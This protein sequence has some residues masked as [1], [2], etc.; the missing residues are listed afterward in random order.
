[1]KKRNCTN[2]IISLFLY[3]FMCGFGLHKSLNC[4]LDWLLRS[5]LILSVRRYFSLSVG[6]NAKLPMSDELW[7]TYCNVW[8]RK[9]WVRDRERI[10]TQSH[11][12]THIKGERKPHSLFLWRAGR[13]FLEK[14]IKE[15]GESFDK[16]GEPKSRYI[17][18]FQESQRRDLQHLTRPLC[19]LSFFPF[20]LCQFLSFFIGFHFLSLF[21]FFW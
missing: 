19:M 21:F 3:L 14:K 17:L 2:R 18:G 7:H 6:S 16:S 10:H 9:E 11:T 20:F 15:N 13:E 12:L 5:S 8:E 1:M 4:F